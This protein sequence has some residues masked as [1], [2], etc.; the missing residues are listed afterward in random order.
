[1]RFAS[2]GSGSRGNATV[3]QQGRT[4]VL[5]DCGFSLKETERRLARL[6]LQ[7]ETLTAVLVTH[8]HGDHIGGVGAL[9]RKYAL[10]VWMSAGT[11]SSGVQGRIDEVRH[12]NC[13]EAFAVGEL[14]ITPF[15][16]PH[17][18]REPSQFVLGTGARRLGLLTDTGMITPHIRER[19]AACDALM[20]ECNHDPLMLREGPYPAVLKARVGGER[21]HL[22]NQQAAGLLQALPLEGLQHIVAAHISDKNNTPALARQ[23]LAQ[24][25][26][27]T[28]DWV[29]V[30]DQSDGL[31]WREIA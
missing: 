9:A 6:G 5:V 1:M 27:C 23:A 30:A 29:A 24:A 16:V 8:E 17:D 26:G 2:L 13:H 25:L 14:A 12:F 10:P 15:P 28:P 21:G 11:E 22:S 18:S 20:L 19:L 31:D 7:A 4:T 3:V